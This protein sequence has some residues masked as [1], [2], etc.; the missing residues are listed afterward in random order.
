VR[1]VSP[2]FHA[3]NGRLRIKISK[4]KGSAPKAMEVEQLLREVEGI[5]HVQANAT[6]GNVLIRYHPD[7]IDQSAV[8]HALQR[9][10]YLRQDEVVQTPD[11]RHSGALEGLGEAMAETLVRTAIELAVQRLVSALI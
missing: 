4:I 6:T 9:L 10:G 3:L 5:R 7:Q 11:R 2:Y 8:L 1:A